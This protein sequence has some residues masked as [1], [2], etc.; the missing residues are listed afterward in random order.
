M[1]QFITIYIYIYTIATP[2]SHKLQTEI[3][4]HR[5]SSQLTLHLP[6]NQC[7]TAGQEGIAFFWAY[8]GKLN[9]PFKSRLSPSGCKW[10]MTVLETTRHF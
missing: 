8:T 1:Y 7:C 9:A 6:P 3:E 2:K 5:I 10:I 4:E